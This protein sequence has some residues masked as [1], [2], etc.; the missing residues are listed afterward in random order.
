MFS[1]KDGAAFLAAFEKIKIEGKFHSLLNMTR[2]ILRGP[3]QRGGGTIIKRGGNL[4]RVVTHFS[5]PKAPKIETF[6]NF[7]KKLS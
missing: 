7:W 4:G 5:A 2:D 1:N 3:T 6:G